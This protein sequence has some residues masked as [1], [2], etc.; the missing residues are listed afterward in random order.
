L[1][2]KDKESQEMIKRMRE[3]AEMREEA[4]VELDGNQE[5]EEELVR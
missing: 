4:L 5:R 3:E 2:K 1:T